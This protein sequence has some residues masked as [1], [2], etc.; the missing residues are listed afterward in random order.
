MRFETAR[1]RAFLLKSKVEK[2]DILS[3]EK[4]EFINF[5]SDISRLESKEKEHIESLQNKI[6][7]YEAANYRLKNEI[8][9]LKE[10]LNNKAKRDVIEFHEI[11]NECKSLIRT[12]L[13][14]P[15]TNAEKARITSLLKKINSFF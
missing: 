5:F 3:S 13:F 6:K 14:Y 7:D 15:A 10:K 8:N 2:S 1:S 4:D 9:D 12:V 11:L